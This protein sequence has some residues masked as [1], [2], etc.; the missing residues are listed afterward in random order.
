VTPTAEPT[1]GAAN[2]YTL[3]GMVYVISPT[4]IYS[5]PTSESRK[6]DDVAFGEFVA[7][8]DDNGVYSA[9]EYY[10]V[11][12]RNGVN[13]FLLVEATTDRIPANS[14]TLG[15]QSIEPEDW[16]SLSEAI[17]DDYWREHVN[18]DDTSLV[19]QPVS[20]SPEA[21]ASYRKRFRF[22]DGRVNHKFQ[23]ITYDAISETKL[24][25]N[26]RDSQQSLVACGYNDQGE[27]VYLQEF[28]KED[29][30]VTPY[31][32]CRTGTAK[33]GSRV[34]EYEFVYNGD[35]RVLVF[36]EE[37]RPETILVYRYNDVI[38]MG[39]PY[40]RLDM[41]YDGALLRNIVMT[42]SGD[43]THRYN[44]F[45]EYRDGYLIRMVS[46]VI[47]TEDDQWSVQSGWEMAPAE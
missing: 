12:Y 25:V 44:T 7:L 2:S 8:A 18:T 3:E 20:D 9:A 47:R 21:I 28:V 36:G 46:L 22:E 35:N 11:Q 16:T 43:D 45:F 17:L 34:K 33:D 19:K 15:T 31:D 29:S 23:T 5:E 24:L 32:S 14:V 30:F 38:S 40:C 4:T 42:I 27:M 41:N 39:S 1:S 26:P 37:D 6:L 10:M 13:G